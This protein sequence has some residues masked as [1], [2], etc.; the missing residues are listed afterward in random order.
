M[1]KGFEDLIW[2][3]VKLANH[4]LEDAAGASCGFGSAGMKAMEAAEDNHQIRH[5]QLL[6]RAE[7]EA[8][9]MGQDDFFA[10]G[11]L[12]GWLDGMAKVAAIKGL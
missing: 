7:V 5:S 6:G 3:L 1:P 8:V 9:G 2:G 4:L 10:L 11:I 12:E